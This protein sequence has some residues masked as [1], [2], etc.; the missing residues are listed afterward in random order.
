MKNLFKLFNLLTLTITLNM[1]AQWSYP[2]G[3]WA[4]NAQNSTATGE[5]AAAMGNGT[6]ASG[7]Y[8]TSMGDNTTA[9]GSASTSM[10]W[11]STASEVLLQ[12]WEDSQ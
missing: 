5:Y 9:S 8:S 4:M 3:N 10:G 1:N 2:G 6:T 7:N 12:Q 11:W